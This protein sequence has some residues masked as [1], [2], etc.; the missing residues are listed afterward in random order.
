MTT[1]GSNRQ[2]RNQKQGLLILAIVLS[3]MIV[4]YF[5]FKTGWGMPTNTINKGDL[6]T[7]PQS[8]KMLN[9][10]DNSD[11]LQRLYPAGIKKWRILVPISANCEAACQKNLFITR[12]VHIR[13]AEKVSRVERILLALDE[14]SAQQ[15]QQLLVDHPNVLWLPSSRVELVNWLANT[16]IP[17]AQ[18]D[19]RYFLIDQD[20][21]AMMS[22]SAE[23]TGQDLLED[24]T[25][26]LKY[27][28]EK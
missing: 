28:Y 8:V 17:A 21:F 5:M 18:V 15:K 20:G 26:L 14:V 25:K 10:A 24:L 3:P 16:E 27:T 11:S 7:P 6:L 4:S 9:L 12:Q 19:K 22:Y 2:K 1:D 13:L 23:H